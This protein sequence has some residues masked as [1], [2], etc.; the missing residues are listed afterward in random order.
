MKEPNEIIMRLLNF[1]ELLYRKNSTNFSFLDQKYYDGLGKI[2]YKCKTY[3]KSLCYIENIPFLNNSENFINLI[4][5]YEILDVPE[6]AIG[7]I[8]LA[9]KKNLFNY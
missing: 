3:A 6:A 7:L 5:L 9:N 2:C 1:S 4:K 8:E